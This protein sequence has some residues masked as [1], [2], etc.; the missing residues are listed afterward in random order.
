MSIKITTILFALICMIVG[1]VPTYF[2]TVEYVEL[3]TAA[4]IKQGNKD[5]ASLG[6]IDDSNEIAFVGQ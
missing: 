1:S 5:L 2:A 6:F 4:N 3:K